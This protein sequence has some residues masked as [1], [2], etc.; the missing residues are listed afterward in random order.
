MVDVRAGVVEPI[1]DTDVAAVAKFLRKTMSPTLSE[2]DWIR[3]MT[4][5]WSAEQPNHGY[6]TRDGGQ[7]VGAYLAL[8]SQ[9]VIGGRQR[10]ICN[11]GTWC[12]AEGHRA[13][14][15]GLLRALLRQRGYAFSDLSPIPSVVALNT[16]LGFG[17]LDT[18]TAVVLNLPARS[19][20]VRIVDTPSNIEAIL[21]EP[22][23][24]VYRDHACCVARHIV[25]AQG[26]ECC[27]VMFRRRR[28]KRLPSAELIHI[29]NRDL[30]ERCAPQFYSH[31]LTRH[32]I[33]VTLVETRLAAVTAAR[34][35]RVP[36]PVRMYLGDG[37]QPAC[38]DYLYSELA[39]L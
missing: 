34:S 30:F 25:I 4:P 24:T 20:D 33:P 35:V 10:H 21:R 5:Q 32:H 27:H 29:G 38:V 16:R 37:V 9:R 14:G 3:S 1:T 18:E 12:V 31:L 26:D 13:A 39:W 15:L 17:L 36:G 2:T 6:L 7:I 19:G 22:D 8:Y 28:Y 11:L 23:L